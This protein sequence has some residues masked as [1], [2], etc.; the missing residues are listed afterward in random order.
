MSRAI[1]KEADFLSQQ[2]FQLLQCLMPH[3]LH[4]IK[5]IN[6]LRKHMRIRFRK[7]LS[8]VHMTCHFALSFSVWWLRVLDSPERWRITQSVLISQLCPHYF[9]KYNWHT[10]GNRNYLYCFSVVFVCEQLFPS[11]ILCYLWICCSVHLY[12]YRFIVC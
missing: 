11:L 2:H 4:C 7:T 8:Y 6:A 12:T 1:N 10:L 9:K 5:T 3:R